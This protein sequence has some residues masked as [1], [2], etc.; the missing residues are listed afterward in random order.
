MTSD[1]SQR[2]QRL[3]ARRRGT[4]RMV[5]LDAADQ[6]EILSKSLNEEGGWTKRAASQPFTR[7]T[8]GAMQEV[9]P[10][11]TRVSLE[12]AQRVRAQLDTRLHAAGFQVEF[13][14]QGSVPANVHIRGVSDVD[15]LVLDRSFLTY[16]R[17]GLVSAQG[18]YKNPTTL[19]TETVLT[20]LRNNAETSLEAAFPRASID[21]TGAKA[22][23]ISKGSL[24]RPVD[25]VPSHWHDTI[26]Y[27]QSRQMEDRGVTL[28]DRKARLAIENRPFRHIAKL[29][30]QDRMTGGGLKK[31][32]RLC[33]NVK[34]DA[35]EDGKR[36]G[37]SSFDIAGAM[38]HASISALG[39]GIVY[40]LA[41]LAETQRHLDHLA[42]DSAYARSLWTPDGTRRIFD[43]E[44]KLAGVRS[45]SIEMD[46]LAQA[47]AREQSQVLVGRATPTWQ[48]IN[49][50]LARSNV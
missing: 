1:I 29:G 45:L 2:I 36:I 17:G 4:D 40:E 5:A 37:F 8:L 25:V 23:A 20:R 48:E 19:S 9:G 3:A 35:I 47:V 6:I 26:D 31:A 18:G 16:D 14:V 24:A 30:A 11:Y 28:W 43:N 10:D 49:E 46:A 13:H 42:T 32:I 22:I 15:L 50:V 39:A 41:I 27:Q 38:Y 7:Y 12:T 44:D 34:A 21:K 33:K